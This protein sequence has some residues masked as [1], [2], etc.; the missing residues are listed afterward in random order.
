[1]TALSDLENWYRSQ[2]NGEWEHGEGITIGTL[3]NPGWSIQVSPYTRRIAGDFRNLKAANP[4]K[5]DS[6]IIHCVAAWLYTSLGAQR[7]R[8]RWS[9]LLNE[10]HAEPT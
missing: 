8:G 2:C 5:P 10:F 3:D 6:F 4:D 7:A 1:M 9:A